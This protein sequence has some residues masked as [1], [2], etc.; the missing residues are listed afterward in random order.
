V[1]TTLK[2][3]LKNIINENIGISEWNADLIINKWINLPTTS[4]IIS[5]IH[6]FPEFSPPLKRQET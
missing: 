4:I 2:K 5:L 1:I 3:K 6:G